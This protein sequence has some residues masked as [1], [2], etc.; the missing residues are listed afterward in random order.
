MKNEDLISSLIEEDEEVLSERG[1]KFVSERQKQEA[2]I[3]QLIE[4]VRHYDY[5]F[6]ETDVN[7]ALIEKSKKGLPQRGGKYISI[8]E[9][10]SE[11]IARLEKEAEEIQ[12][13]I[14]YYHS[15]M[16]EAHEERGVSNHFL[17]SLW[18]H[19]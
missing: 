10:R 18:S 17:R 8:K 15:Q 5:L 2:K 12:D 1:G 6:R 7:K 11:E 14:D 13:Y 3:D 9:R 4:K 16:Q 19:M